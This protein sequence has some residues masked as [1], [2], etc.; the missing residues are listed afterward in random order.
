MSFAIGALLHSL[1]DKTKWYKQFYN[2]N[3]ISNN[4]TKKIGVLRIEWFILKTPLRL[5]NQALKIEGRP[6]KEQL[7]K[8]RQVMTA[9]ELSHLIGF[10]VLIPFIIYYIVSGQ[11]LLLIISTIVL[12]ILFNGYTALTQQYNKRRLDRL[13]KRMAC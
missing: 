8:L 9:G 3:F 10:V 4:I 6:N 11:S 13:L 5:F 12:N 1:L 2:L 7:V